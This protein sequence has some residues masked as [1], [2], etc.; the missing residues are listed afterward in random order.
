M[1]IAILDDSDQQLAIAQAQAQL[2]QQ[3]SNLARGDRFDIF[4]ELPEELTGQVT[5]GMAIELTARALPQ[6]KQR[7]TITAV[8][9]S[10]DSASRRQRVR[11]QINNPPPGLL[12]GMAIAGNLNMPTNRSSFV[13]SRDAFISCINFS[14]A[15]E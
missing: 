3:R 1:A 12:P 6:W 9:P 5:P 8:V 4:L 15:K 7:A 10:A 2:A 11:V 14:Y 13:V